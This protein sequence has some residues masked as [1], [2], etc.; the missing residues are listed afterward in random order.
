MKFN[1]LLKRITPL[2]WKKRPVETIANET[3]VLHAANVLP[4]LL[5]AAKDLQDNWEHNLTKPMA[6]LNETIAMVEK[7]DNA[8]RAHDNIL[9]LVHCNI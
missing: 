5:T 2:P 6:R 8:A 3:Y 1:E 4:E 7:I 9:R